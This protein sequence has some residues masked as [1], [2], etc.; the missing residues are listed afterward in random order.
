MNKTPTPAASNK[1]TEQAT[2]TGVERIAIE[3]QRQLE[4]EGWTPEHD[5]KHNISEMACAAACYAMGRKLIVFNGYLRGIGF[6]GE[7]RLWKIWPWDQPD[8]WK[9]SNNPIRNLE[10]A[11]ALIAAEIDRLTRKGVES[12]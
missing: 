9:P 5:D 10:K 3:R 12:R 2:L 11:G 6:E 8:Y 7:P 4:A 1:S